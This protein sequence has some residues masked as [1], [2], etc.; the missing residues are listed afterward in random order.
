MAFFKTADEKFEQGNEYIKR[1]EYDKARSAFDK[2]ISKGAADAEVARVMIA[3]L[4]LRGGG[5]QAY[6]NAANLLREKGEMEVTFGLFTIKCSELTKECDA[7]YTELVASS[8]GSG[9]VRAD[10]LLAAGMK[11]QTTIGPKALIVPDVYDAKKIT[12]IEKANALMAEGNEV[13]GDSMA[14]E[15]PKK[16]AEFLQI[17]M[18]YRRQLGDAGAESRISNKIRQYAKAAACW[19]CGREAT[20]ETINFVAMPTEVTEMQQKSKAT[21]PLPSFEG[22]ASI[23]VC[24][25]C[26]L[27]ISKRA[28][29]IAKQYHD[30]AMNEMRAM[31]ARLNARI[32]QVN[33]RI[34]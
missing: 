27:A 18:N 16:A 14:R 28:D 4:D 19:M 31:E 30:I 7:A 26:Y 25:A 21:S 15:D 6:G 17:A 5:V 33:S 8:T 32:N 12:G 23:Y 29:A 34:R 24:R 20:G 1:K 11:Y 13:L 2:A 3:L 9:K 10:A 22:G